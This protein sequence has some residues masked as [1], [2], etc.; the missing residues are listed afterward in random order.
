MHHELMRQTQYKLQIVFNKHCLHMTSKGEAYRHHL[1]D[2]V[3]EKV[4][5][6]AGHL[7]TA[8]SACPQV[9]PSVK[10]WRRQPN[11]LLSVCHSQLH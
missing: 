1:L 9:L 6:V 8:G 4:F 3:L 11:T 7:G 5:R 2:A 10:K